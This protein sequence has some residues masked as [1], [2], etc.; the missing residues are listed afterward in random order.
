LTSPRSRIRSS[1]VLWAAARAAIVARRWWKLS[2]TRLMHIAV[3]IRHFD[4]LGIPR[5]A[6]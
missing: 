2:A 3:P 6:A 1:E 5:L 4:E